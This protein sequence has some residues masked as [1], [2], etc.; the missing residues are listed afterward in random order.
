MDTAILLIIFNR[1]ET[2]QQVFNAIRQAKPKRLY[3]AADGPRAN[4][5]GEVQRCEAA[6]KVAT[7]VDWDCTVQTLFRDKNL[8]C[9]K[10]VSSGINWFFEHETEGIILEDDCLPSTSF[11]RYCSELLER[12]RDDTRI[13]GIGANNFEKENTREREYSYNFSSLAYIWGWATWKRAWKFIDLKVGHYPELYK[14][15]YLDESYDTTY[16]KDFFNY[17]FGELAKEGGKINHD[18]IWGYQWQFACLVNAGLTIVPSCSLV[19]NIGMGAEA[20]H[21]KDAK[22]LGY[23]LKRE[24]MQFPMIHPEFVMVDR[25]RDTRTFNL[26]HTSPTSRLKSNLKRVIPKPVIEKLVKPLMYMFF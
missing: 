25:R 15:Q 18:K 7:E 13:M 19:S 9:G 4:K 23:D 24:E 11:F 8:G 26:M 20:T 2:T 10:A 16:K 3:V 6:R 17:I 22:S 21:T 5:L 12:Y 1:P 14:K